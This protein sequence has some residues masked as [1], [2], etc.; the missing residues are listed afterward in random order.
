MDKPAVEGSNNNKRPCTRISLVRRS[1]SN[2]EK[3]EEDLGNHSSGNNNSNKEGLVNRKDSGNLKEVD[4]FSHSSSQEDSVNHSNN[5]VDLV[6]HNSNSSRACLAK[7]T[8][9]MHL[10][11]ILRFRM[12]PW[13]SPLP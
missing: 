2:K 9:E 4:L 1:N 8:T 7:P 11:I 5:K 3:A 12:L 10:G 6:N 13:E